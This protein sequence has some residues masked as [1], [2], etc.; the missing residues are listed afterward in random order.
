MPWS[1]YGI[2]VVFALFVL[3]MVVNPKLSCFGKRIGSPLYPL[4]RKKK[5]RTLKTEDYGFHLVDENGHRKKQPV[6]TG[7]NTHPPV[8]AVRKKPQKAVKTQDY[9]FHLVDGE[10]DKDTGATD[11]RPGKKGN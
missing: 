8:K 1:V 3:L 6:Q 11:S 9:G 7:G 10:G 4:L 5:K 2:L